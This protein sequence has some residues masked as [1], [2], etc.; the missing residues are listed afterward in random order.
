[1][2]GG[3]SCGSYKVRGGGYFHL[4]QS[5]I[6]KVQNLGLKTEYDT[7]LDFNKMVKRIIALACVPI[8]DVVNV[9]R[10]LMQEFPNTPECDNLLSYFETTYI[11]GPLGRDPLFKLE[12]WNQ[13][14]C[15]SKS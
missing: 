1:M 3:A 13:Y 15:L 4:S 10:S 7:N 6:R 14:D 5:V 11:S 9:F 12:L 8:A 2:I